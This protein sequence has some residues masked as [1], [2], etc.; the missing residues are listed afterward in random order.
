V[1]ADYFKQ[2]NIG[3]LE[4]NRIFKVSFA[5]SFDKNNNSPEILELCFIKTKK[6]YKFFGYNTYG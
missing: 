4:S 2:L 5:K 3:D 6:G 1:E